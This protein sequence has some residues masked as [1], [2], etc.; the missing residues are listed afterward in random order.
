MEA[1]GLVKVILV[2]VFVFGAILNS[3][4]AYHWGKADRQLPGGY[5]KVSVPLFKNKSM[6]VGIEA[7]FTKAM[8]LELERSQVAQVASEEVSDVMVQG[9]IVSLQYFPGSK[10]Q[11]DD[12]SSFLP[13]GT[14][15]TSS[16]TIVANVEISLVRR[17][18]NAVIWS[19]NF[20]G[21]RAYVAPQVT[22]PG[23]N[24]VN[25]LYN[26]S[27]RRQNIEVIAQDMMIEVHDRLTESF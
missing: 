10:K 25:P 4:C 17:S 13:S 8:L 16:Y 14:V 9:K 20:S 26:L 19:A 7:L 24:S 5:K 21:E 2:I 1:R 27:A 23:I 11:Y 22:L 3:S 12:G 15:L 6:E 18:D